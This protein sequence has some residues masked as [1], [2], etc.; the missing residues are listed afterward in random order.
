M[1]VAWPSALQSSAAWSLHW[2]VHASHEVPR[3]HGWK[4]GWRSNRSE[5]AREAE[6]TGCETQK[7]VKRTPQ[8]AAGVKVASAIAAPP[9]T[10]VPVAQIVTKND[11]HIGRRGHRNDNAKASMARA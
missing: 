4:F 5:E 7:S 6:H 8:A 11:H 10:K 2:K 3:L 1:A 9:D